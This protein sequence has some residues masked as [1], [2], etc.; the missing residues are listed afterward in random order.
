M[1]QKLLN[2][3]KML[4]TKLLKLIMSN[5]GHKELFDQYEEKIM[6]YQP[7]SIVIQWHLG[8]TFWLYLRDV[9]KFKQENN[10]DIYKFD[11]VADTSYGKMYGNGKFVVVVFNNSLQLLPGDN[12]L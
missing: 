9:I 4:T 8:R 5:V 1:F 3:P 7:S 6:H 2:N 11:V 10:Q 12:D